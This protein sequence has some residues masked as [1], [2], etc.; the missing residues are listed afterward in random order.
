MFR[1][2][3]GAEELFVGVT[4]GE[5]AHRERD[6]ASWEERAA[7]VRAFVET[8]DLVG[9]LTVRPLEDA[10]GPAATGD[11]DAIVVS[12]E[13]RHA[14]AGINARR[15]EGGLRPL[16]PL[17]VPHVLGED[18]LPV[19]ATAIA[20][21]RIDRAG[22]RLRPVVV[23]VGSA[24]PVKVA[25]VRQAMARFL[26]GVDHAVRGAVVAS[27]VAE[28]PVGRATLEGARTRARAALGDAD[29][30][31][32]VEA[33]LVTMPGATDPVD[34]QACVVRDRAGRETVGW[35]PAFCHP[36]E[37]D[38]RAL[39]GEMVSD[40][41]GPVADDP[42]I[43]GTTGAIGFLSNGDMDR[44]ELTSL[45]VRM[46]LVPRVRPALYTVGIEA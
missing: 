16:R 24:N 44:E 36:P 38:R 45:A 4:N 1:A 9:S 7:A 6:V 19:S 32:G 22:R 11:F 10:V 18:R 5:L 35:G 25:G 23:L 14:V 3:G 39:A 31:V 42:R 17:V 29:Y 46:A 43:G 21:G 34:V 15:S 2:A 20:A 28:Q 33:G 30:A 13:T 8:H 41:L 12:P 40:V 27:G 37:V 26:H